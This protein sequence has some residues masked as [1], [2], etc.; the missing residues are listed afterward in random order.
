M[1][2]G[3]LGLYVC[4]KRPLWLCTFLFE[5]TQLF[6]AT[7]TDTVWHGPHTIVYII[8]EEGLF[9][10]VCPKRPLGPLTILK[11]CLLFAFTLRWAKLILH[12]PSIFPIT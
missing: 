1:K 8:M 4:L 12:C 5:A 7:S 10:I 6:L 3:L 9:E 2:E 11:I